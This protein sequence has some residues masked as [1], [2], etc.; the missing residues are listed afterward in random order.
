ML[1]SSLQCRRISAQHSTSLLLQWTA[2][3][4]FFRASSVRAM[5]LASSVSSG[6]PK[7]K[8]A[9]AQLCSKSSKW[10]NLLN[11]AKCAGWATTVTKQETTPCSMLFL[12]ECFGFLGSSSEQTLLAAEPAVSSMTEQRQQNPAKMTEALIQMVSDSA[13]TASD[14]NGS[15]SDENQPLP[16]ALSEHEERSISLLDGLR[17]IAVASHLWISAGSMH[18]AVDDDDDEPQQQQQR[19]Y[20]THII[21]DPSGTVRAEYRKIHLFDVCIPGKVD[22]RESKTTKAGTELVVCPDSPIGTTS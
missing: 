17:T 14:T 11:V 19:V 15:A 22:L 8:I 3:L 13:A 16:L 6:N 5:S 2:A 18:V 12:P 7:S 1:R 10:E 20:N 21:V 9:A 4:F